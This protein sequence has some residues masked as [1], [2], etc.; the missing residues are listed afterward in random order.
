MKYASPE[1]M[2]RIFNP[3]PS[4]HTDLQMLAARESRAEMGVDFVK[5]AQSRPG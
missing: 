2:Q 5:Y 4:T 3:E 1:I